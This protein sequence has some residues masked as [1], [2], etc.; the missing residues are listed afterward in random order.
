MGKMLKCEY[1]IIMIKIII[2]NYVFNCFGFFLLFYGYKFI[3]LLSFFFLF[4]VLNELIFI[5][6]LY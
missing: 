2:E 4:C 1:I 6:C 3:Y 5:E